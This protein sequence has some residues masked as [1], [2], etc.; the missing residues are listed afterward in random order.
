MSG[1][2]PF[3]RGKRLEK[4]ENKM[5]EKKGSLF[6]EKSMEKV[7]SPEQLDAYIRVA[8]PGVWIFFAALVLLLLGF[9]V[10]SVFG[11]IDMVTQEGGTLVTESVAPIY[12][13][14]N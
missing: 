5:E 6:R 8:S 11:R 10:W 1:A 14:T 4:M 2:C 7:A 12:F 9:L 13:V 3:P